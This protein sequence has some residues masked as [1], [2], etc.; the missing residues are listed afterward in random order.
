MRKKALLA[1]ATSSYE[2]PWV[3][4]EA[5]DW[6]VEL[7]PDFKLIIEKN[8]EIEKYYSEEPSIRQVDPYEIDNI[9]IPGPTRIRAIVSPDYKG[10]GIF[11][12]A[13]QVST[14]GDKP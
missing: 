5:G 2:G 6:L 13:K 12:I 7:S 9:Y 8:E 11:L 14:N 4:L 1:G 10:P 3:N